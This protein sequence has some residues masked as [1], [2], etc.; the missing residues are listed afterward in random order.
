MSTGHPVVP[1]LAQSLAS[2]DSTLEQKDM[3]DTKAKAV[4]SVRMEPGR[5]DSSVTQPGTVSE[6]DDVHDETT[7]HDHSEEEN[8]GMTAVLRADEDRLF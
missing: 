3:T 4:K 5:V 8:D 7:D 1:P 6:P 2:S